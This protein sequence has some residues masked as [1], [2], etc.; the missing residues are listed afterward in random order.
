MTWLL[1]VFIFATG[2][3][4][5]TQPLV[6]RTGDSNIEAVD[7]S[8]SYL[9]AKEKIEEPTIESLQKISFVSA[10][11]SLPNLGYSRGQLVAK[12]EFQNQ[13]NESDWILRLGNPHL[14]KL[15]LF[16]LK[17]NQLNERL[18]TGIEEPFLSRPI[19]FREFWLPLK[20]EP[21]KT[22][23]FYLI[24]ESG[25]WLGLIPYLTLPS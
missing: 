5:T 9:P 16:E 1:S 8:Y 13:S 20:L 2:F 25:Q 17:D 12:F 4:E 10:K 23:T 21:N 7:F 14:K 3:A 15:R 18:R 6:L 24:T 11:R 22:Q 19:L